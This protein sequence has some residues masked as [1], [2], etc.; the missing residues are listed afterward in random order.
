MKVARSHICDQQTLAM[1]ISIA[2]YSPT[3][4]IFVWNTPSISCLPC[5]DCYHLFKLINHNSGIKASKCIHHNV[6][7]CIVNSQSA[8][9][10]FI[11]FLSFACP[12]QSARYVEYNQNF[13]KS[14]GTK[15]E[16]SPFKNMIETSGFFHCTLI[17][18]GISGRKGILKSLTV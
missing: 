9:F 14:A 3:S 4:T 18:K 11:L 16:I 12:L 15:I 7:S 17:C 8:L 6:F 1:C 2:I 13:L 10:D 5:I